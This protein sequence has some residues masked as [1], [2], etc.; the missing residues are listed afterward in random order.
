MCCT[1]HPFGG[2]QGPRRFGISHFPKST[3]I[4]G[5]CLY[6]CTFCSMGRHK[7]QLRGSSLCRRRRRTPG[8]PQI[9]IKRGCRPPSLSLSPR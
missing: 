3:H 8:H 5:L 6:V 4:F 1:T 9:S 7:E 2:S